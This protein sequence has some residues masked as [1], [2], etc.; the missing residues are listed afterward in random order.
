M[1]AR[2]PAVSLLACAWAS[3]ILAC[4]EHTKPKSES[5]KVEL[6]VARERTWPWKPGDDWVEPDEP[7]LPPGELQELS[8]QTSSCYGWCAVQDLILR[9]DGAFLY[10]G[11]HHARYEGPLVGDAPM[12]AKYVFMLASAHP[13][14]AERARYTADVTDDPTRSFT[15]LDERGRH[16]V[17]VYGGPQFIPIP[18][19]LYRVETELRGWIEDFGEFE[20]ERVEPLEFDNPAPPGPICKQYG[21]AL[22]ERCTTLLDGGEPTRSC[23]HHARYA[24]LAQDLFY[25]YTAEQVEPVCSFLLESLALDADGSEARVPADIEVSADDRIVCK[26]WFAKLLVGRER[27]DDYVDK[28][29]YTIDCEQLFD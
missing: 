5:M 14:G 7:Q 29:G 23:L 8:Y 24:A 10:M 12:M 18:W 20:G 26:D 28:Q 13:F 21:D 16:S 3:L 9:R 1:P 4:T 11:R 27:A 2:V 17:V 6:S 19:A 22:R 25:E 15:T